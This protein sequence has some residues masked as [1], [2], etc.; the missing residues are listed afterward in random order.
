MKPKYFLAFS[1]VLC[2]ACTAQS[3][4]TKARVPEDAG[5]KKARAV[6]DRMIQAMGGDAFLNYRDMSQSGRTAA[7]YHGNPSSMSTPY[8]LFWKWPDMERVEFTKQRDVVLI[9]NGDKGYET[10]Y[11]GT[12][13]EDPEDLKR[14]LRDHQYALQ[15]VLRRWLRQPGTVLIYDGVGIADQKQVDKVTILNPNNQSVT[16]AIDTFSHLLVRKS[17]QWRDP[18]TRYID[19]EAEVYSNY[20]LVQGI[21]TPRSL[22]TMHNGDVTRQRFIDNTAYNTGIADSQFQATVTYDPLEKRK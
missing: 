17:Y 14:Y 8:W 9:H 21:Q 19:E 16:L 11:K 6:L 4:P 10:T 5:D 1:L 18:E 13:L 3:A 22:V 2:A 7:F 12:R 20:H 15:V